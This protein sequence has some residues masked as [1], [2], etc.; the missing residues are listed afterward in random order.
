MLYIPNITKIS[1][2]LII[3]TYVITRL[4][5]LTKKKSVEFKNYNLIEII[6]FIY[7]GMVLDLI[8]LMAFIIT[9]I[10]KIVLK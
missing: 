9:L 8:K 7:I 3:G 6:I 10:R 4:V 5:V 2:A 1:L